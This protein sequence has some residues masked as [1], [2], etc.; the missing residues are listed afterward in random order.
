MNRIVYIL[1]FAL[2]LPLS[3]KAQPEHLTLEKCREMAIETNL[4]LKSSQE[5]IFASEDMFKAYKS[6]NR[7]KISLSGNYLYS[8]ASLNMTL[9]GGYL[10]TFT[11]DLTTGEMIPNI[12]GYASDG[13]AIFSSY[14]Y[15]P[16][17][18]LDLKVGSVFN[19]SVMLAQPIYMGGKIKTAT[20]LAKVGVEAS[21]IE[22]IRTESEVIV[23]ADEA[24]YTYLKVEEILRSADAYRRVVDEFQ[25]QVESLLE[26]G[27][28]TKNDLLKVE[29]RTNEAKLQQ[30]KARNGL[31]LARMN[32]CYVI[33]L[34]LT[35]RELTVVDEFDLQD[36]IDPS[37]DITRRPEYTLLAKNI[38]AKEL[39]VLLAESDF[40]P[41]ISA[42]ASYGYTNGLT[43]NS[44]TLMNNT[45]F[46][47]GVM[48]N[49]PIFNWGEGRRKVSA[50]RREVKMAEN[51]KEDLELKMTLE[52]M[53][54]INAY[55]EA[56]A[57][58]SLMEDTL[59]QA[60]ENLRQSE[61]L[62]LSG[63]ET[64]SEYLEAQAIWQKA[65]SDLIESKSN[66]RL[67]HIRY[68]RSRGVLK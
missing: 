67:A 56:R 54:S 53:Q 37:L 1:V 9:D 31:T 68:N 51:T 12:V 35:T 18:N 4:N 26:R 5:K 30:L 38:E 3:A 23:A 43:F 39:E 17:I 66:Q 49:I 21:K 15:S 40:K 2:A 19:T 24:F 59:L 44:S 62:Y 60:E 16:D 57:E 63:M 25:R 61:K 33:G 48:L 58:V 13:S 42:L 11:P 64:L 65:M 6:N 29:V 46:T 14:A 52:L 27:M 28:C 7:P 45:T 50:A 8:T 20:R 41:S 34:P 10:P 55:N 47:G 36:N 32:L 22:R